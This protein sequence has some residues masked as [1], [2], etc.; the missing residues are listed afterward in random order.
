M[1]PNPGPI[2]QGGSPT[3]EL[4]PP[5]ISAR[6]KDTTAETP[7]K[8]MSFYLSFLAL[9]ITVFIVSLDLTELAVAVPRIVEDLHGTTLGAFWTNLSFIL[10]VVITQPIYSSISDVLGRKL[11]LYTSFLFFFAGS[12]IFAIA[13]NM[14]VL[15]AGRVLQGLGAGGLDVLGEVIL[16]DITTLKE[17]PLYLGLFALPMA[18]GGISGPIIGA[19]F[20]EYVSWRWI[21]WIN[22]P[23]AG[24]GL[25]LAFFFLRLRPIDR[26]LSSKLLQL[27]WIGMLLFTLGSTLFALPLSWAGALYPWSSW[28]TILPFVTG[29]LIL[30]AFGL[31]EK[32]ATAPIF[33]YRLFQSTT[34]VVTL[35]GATI[36]GMLLYSILIYAPLFFQ[37]VLLETPIQSAVSILPAGV[38]IVGF[39]VLA[40]IAVG[41]IRRY[42]WVI[43]SSWILA[44]CGVGLWALWQRWTSSALKNGLQVIAGI[45]IGTLFTVLTIPLQATVPDANDM[46]IAAGMLVSFRLFGGLTGLAICST[47]FNNVFEKRIASIAQ[48]PQA[49]ERVRDSREAVAFI[50]MLRSFDRQSEAFTQIVEAY[51]VAMLAVFLMLAGLG[52]V[53]LVTSLFTRE[54]SIERDDLG[55]Q[56]LE[57]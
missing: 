14:S 7:R 57:Y 9:N 50:P 11:P 13:N 52:A 2:S 5:T 56:Q 22:L 21:G 36:H 30:V 3:R 24:V 4:E 31:Y 54:L 10:A 26:S 46:G 41:V 28:K 37:A 33:P 19:V 20:S 15:I 16:S 51:R 44:A 12:I 39:S 49:M 32:K 45:G 27:D 8:P 34:A 43:I 1:D 55:R 18:G 40:A 6:E 47:V 25:L 38:T 48:L 42:R 17:R 29:C 35:I 53:G 23:V